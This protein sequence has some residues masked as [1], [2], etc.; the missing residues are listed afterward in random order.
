MNLHLY[1][2]EFRELVELSA[3]HF[4]YQQSHIE[5]DYW[6]CKILKDLALSGFSENV[7]LKGGTSLS[8]GYGLIYRFS[9]DLDVFV[10]SGSL[11]SSKQAEKTLN[12][13]ISHFVI[14]NNREM[15]AEKM[16]KTG[17]DFRKLAFSY[18]TQYKSAGL[19]ENI[20]V[21]IK[22]CTLDDKSAMFYPMQK[23]SIQSIISKYLYM[24]ENRD[25]IVRFGLYAFDTQTIDPKRTLCDKISRLTR[26]S[27]GNNPEMLIAKHI[28][29]VYDIYCL[30]NVTEYTDFVQSEDFFDA[31]QRVTAED[32]LYRN[33]QQQK[34]IS[35]AGIFSEP[36]KTLKLPDVY[37]AYNRDLKQM[38]FDPATLPLL[39]E[40]INSFILLQQPLLHFDV[41]MSQMR[42]NS[43]HYSCFEGG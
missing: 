22:C 11:A 2:E 34:P 35:K 5:K 4:G 16:S 12:R 32:G 7:Y 30:L 24:I 10:Y 20:E 31:L 13:N 43:E 36:E 26:L 15:Y 40:V 21:E 23:R 3:A 25:I 37:R 14:E 41:N 17:G 9:E 39:N 38:M 27:Y 18:D 33:S 29:D 1:G 28:R 6:I 42:R 8:K 19:K